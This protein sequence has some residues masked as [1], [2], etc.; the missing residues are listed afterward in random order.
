MELKKKISNKIG[1]KKS[2][3]RTWLDLTDKELE[4]LKINTACM[5]G[6]KE[7]VTFN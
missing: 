1:D 3:K 7:K 6:R 4:A 5:Y 2:V